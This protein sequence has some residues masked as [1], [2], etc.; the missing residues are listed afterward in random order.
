MTNTGGSWSRQQVELDVPGLSIAAGQAYK[1]FPEIKFGAIDDFDNSSSNATIGT[2]PE[3]GGSQVYPYQDSPFNLEV[4]SSDATD[5]ELG[6]GGRRCLLQ[7]LD[8]DWNLHTV[9]FAL[10]GLTPVVVPNPTTGKQWLRVISFMITAAGSNGINAGVI[11]ARIPGGTP[12]EMM[13]ILI[14]AGHSIFALTTIPADFIGFIK[15]WQL[16]AMPEGGIEGGGTGQVPQ[17]VGGLMLRN[18][19]PDFNGNTVAYDPGAGDL[20]PFYTADVSAGELREVIVPL[21][22]PPTTDVELRLFNVDLNNA[23]IAGNFQIVA[24]RLTEDEQNGNGSEAFRRWLREWR[25]FF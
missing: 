19:D 10:N 6:T 22:L 14:R 1:W 24:R 3:Q 5:T 20:P 25:M 8:E 4:V 23:A 11:T 7:G 16:V 12:I 17:F 18:N 9:Y 15:T 2:L 13:N 21:L